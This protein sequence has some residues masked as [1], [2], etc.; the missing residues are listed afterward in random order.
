MRLE[1]AEITCVAVMCVS[2]YTSLLLPLSSFFIAL[3]THSRSISATSPL[4]SQL[5]LWLYSFGGLCLSMF[6]LTLAFSENYRLCAPAYLCCTY[7]T[8]LGNHGNF[9]GQNL[10]KWFA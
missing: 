1:L 6:F 4:S 9:V 2:G 7:F 8:L 10:A 5:S 3:K